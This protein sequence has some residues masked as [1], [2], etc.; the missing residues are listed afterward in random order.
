[1]FH[2]LDNLICQL[3]H[4]QWAELISYSRHGAWRCGKPGC[5]SQARQDVRAATAAQVLKLE[6]ARR[7]MRQSRPGRGGSDAA[8]VA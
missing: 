8:R 7:A 2:V 1:M 5:A 3:F 6:A 4:G